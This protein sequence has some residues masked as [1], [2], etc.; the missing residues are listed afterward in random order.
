[1]NADEAQS[2]SCLLGSPSTD[3]DD[4]S[5]AN[6]QQSRNNN[7]IAKSQNNNPM[8]GRMPF[9]A[10]N[11]LPPLPPQFQFGTPPQMNLEAMQAMFMQVDQPIS[12]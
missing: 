1:L 8:M 11:L 6:G 10:T 3:S 2:S 5:P 12:I 7:N 9:G 4:N